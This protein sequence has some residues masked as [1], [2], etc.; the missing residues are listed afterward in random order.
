MRNYCFYQQ[1]VECILTDGLE[2]RTQSELRNIVVHLVVGFWKK[3]AMLK[4][5]AKYLVIF[6]IAIVLATVA[7][8]YASEN[9]I[10]PPNSSLPED[11][12]ESRSWI[13]DYKL[14][15]WNRWG[16]DEMPHGDED[17]SR[18]VSLEFAGL[19]Q[20]PKT[21]IF[22]FGARMEIDAFG[23]RL[24]A[25]CTMRAPLRN[26]ERFSV[27]LTT[28]IFVLGGEDNLDK[29][30]PGYFW[31]IEIGLGRYCSLALEREHLRGSDYSIDPATEKKIELA[32]SWTQ[33]RGGI[34]VWN[35]PGM[36]STL[37]LLAVLVATAEIEFG[38]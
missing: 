34:K 33:V 5:F 15:I 25:M 11:A 36:A 12:V 3:E 9:G 19:F 23:P 24:G 27:Q 8:I 31:E 38:D 26:A 1:L 22:G 37:V 6:P 13:L 21:A 17:H 30:W 14:G 32:S 28:G 20:K 2:F 4:S 10:S 35:T 7:P 29:T 18:M 16:G